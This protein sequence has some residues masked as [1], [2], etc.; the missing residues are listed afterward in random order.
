MSELPDTSSIVLFDGICNFCN[1]S[2]NKI[3]A[4][5]K[6][7]RFKFA[8]LQSEIGKKLLEKHGI[9][10][11]KT[12]SIVLVENGAAF[13][14]STAI[15]QISKHLGGLYPI[16]YVFLIIPVFLRDVVYDFIAKNRY[17]WWGKKES[18]M[19]PTAEVRSKFIEFSPS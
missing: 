13:I 6:K 14:K 11:A 1:S 5:D 12:D 4:Q 10:P 3:I 2:V 7:N 15:L 17:R 8:T 16:A 19:I 9:N 18:C